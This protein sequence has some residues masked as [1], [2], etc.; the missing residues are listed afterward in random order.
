MSAGNPHFIELKSYMHIGMSTQ[1]LEEDRML[2]MSEV[3]RFASRLSDSMERFQVMDE[4]EISRIV[5]LQNKERY[6]DRW[7]KEYFAE[8]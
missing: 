1:R 3:Q 8:S 2:E 6:I 5:V 4:S 7:I